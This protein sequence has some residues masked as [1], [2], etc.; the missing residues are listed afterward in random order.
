MI[1]PTELSDAL[2]TAR[3]ILGETPDINL[4]LMSHQILTNLALIEA[5]EKLRI[6]LM[7]KL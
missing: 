3:D 5:I 4:Q 6:D 1:L 2:D 7:K